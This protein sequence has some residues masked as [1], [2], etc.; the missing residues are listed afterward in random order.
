M[1]IIGE[2]INGAIPSMAKAIAEKDETHIKSI[3]IAQAK[4]GATFIDVC[5]SV[6]DTIEMETMEWLINLVQDAVDRPIAVDSPNTLTCVNCMPFCKKPGLL[7]SVSLEGTKIDDAFPALA[8]AQEWEVVALLNDDTGIPKTA[9]KRLEVFEGIMKRA[10]EFGIAPH[11][12]HIDPLVEMLCTSEEGIKMVVEVITEIKKQYPTIHITGA[13]SN[14]SFNLPVRK[15]VNQGFIVLAMNAGMDS[16]ILD[17][18][19]RDMMGMI[20]AT[21]GLLGMDDYCMEYI[22]AYRAGIFG[23]VQK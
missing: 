14:I 8:Q 21:E 1:I 6:D 18:L 22:G 15:L 12:F 16:A 4:A 13:V 11:R 20:Y 2:K 5:A 17:P 10:K 7:N 9:E 19:N 3:A 23:L